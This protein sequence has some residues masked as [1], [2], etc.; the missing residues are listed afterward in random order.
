MREKLKTCAKRG[1]RARAVLGVDGV[2]IA[3]ATATAAAAAA[4]AA[5]AVA[6]AAAAAAAAATATAATAIVAAAVAAVSE[7][8][9]WQHLGDNRL[10]RAY[11]GSRALVELDYVSPVRGSETTNRVHKQLVMRNVCSA[12]MLCSVL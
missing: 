12:D 4:A 10:Q 5:A 9:V 2:I 3:T 7:L 1:G 6:A 8:C 11:H